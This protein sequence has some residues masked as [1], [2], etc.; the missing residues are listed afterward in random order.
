MRDIPAWFIIAAFTLVA[1]LIAAPILGSQNF[2]SDDLAG[3]VALVLRM[4]SIGGDPWFYDRAWF[5]G[6]AAFELY[7]F[8]PHWI[9]AKLIGWFGG[10]WAGSTQAV[11]AVMFVSIAALPL[12]AWW[13]VR[14]WR[15]SSENSGL[16]AGGIVLVLALFLSV[17]NTEVPAG[18][19]A[20]V[21]SGVFAQLPGWV[22]MLV[23]LGLLGRSLQRGSSATWSVALGF[24]LLM[25]THPL[26][27]VAALMVGFVLLGAYSDWRQILAHGA[28]MVATSAW[29]WL[30]IL[31]WS[32]TYGAG[33]P[34]SGNATLVSVLLDNWLDFLNGI[35]V[36]G[37]ALVVE[38]LTVL[39]FA[40]ALYVGL[41]RS[42]RSGRATIMLIFLG[43]IL[44]V[45]SV[46]EAFPLGIHYDRE[47]V[48]VFLAA[49]LIAVLGGT[50]GLP[51]ISR[52]LGLVASGLLLLIATKGV[53]EQL[54]S[55]PWLSSTSQFGYFGEQW[56]LRYLDSLP[57]E[58]RVQF[59][60]PRER[61]GGDPEPGKY[62]E[63]RLWD[64]AE[65]ETV[66]GVLIQSSRS[67]QLY[68][69]LMA[70][71]GGHSF[72]VPS[73]G[74][75]YLT[76][77]E[78]DVVNVLRRN[79]ITHLISANKVFAEKLAE[80]ESLPRIGEVGRYRFHGVTESMPR[81]RQVK[82]PIIGY[83]DL[84]GNLPF[85]YL[86]TFIELRQSLSGQVRL[87]SLRPDDIGSVH[88]D[89]MIINMDSEVDEIQWRIVSVGGKTQMPVLGIHFDPDPL[90]ENSSRNSHHEQRKYEQ[91]AKY[92]WSSEFERQVHGFGRRE[93]GTRRKEVMAPQFE[94]SNNGQQVTFSE[95]VPGQWYEFA[96][97]FF[98]AWEANGAKLYEGSA[99]HW[100]FRPNE[101]T[102][103]A[104]YD[105][106]N[107]IPV[108]S[109]W[110]LSLVAFL[111]LWAVRLWWP[112]WEVGRSANE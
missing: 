29:F 59:E 23:Y 79:S 10:G 60:Y 42:T 71:W 72:G 44:A 108:V 4:A 86:D 102:V 78:E 37:W 68:T 54:Q 39:I 52:K 80:I 95:L 97:S 100:I 106:W 101:P 88:V 33:M 50:E 45:P 92:M 30:P 32:S 21:S 51:K 53:T 103:R 34:Y 25:A 6:F 3:H 20:V 110:L 41:Y 11:H 7:G 43:F 81:L 13:F 14:A 26:T 89:G 28:A 70:E 107:T 40:F 99:G 74:E 85:R 16:L 27:A 18:I 83:V 2:Y 90:P 64:V 69:T 77:D 15:G 98:P 104:R 82:K 35:S 67:Y 56:S 93:Q 91:A 63:S 9:A 66:N 46:T 61:E 112:F 55:H 1:T 22:L 65:I 48:S 57:S 47:V 62:V 109:G 96:Y 58:S 111:V 24:S 76:I 12:S 36:S 94:W 5:S 38:F 49:A 8:I 87:V 75:K 84:Q 17:T 19:R 31:T 73:I 105:R